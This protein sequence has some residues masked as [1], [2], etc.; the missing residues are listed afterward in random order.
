MSSDQSG[1]TGGYR[2]YEYQVLVTVWLALKLMLETRMCEAIEVEP[3]SN[4]DIQAKLDVPPDS[5]NGLLGFVANGIELDVQVKSR[6]S[7]WTESEFT[8]VITGEPAKGPK[9]KRPAAAKRDRAFDRLRAAKTLRYLLVTNAQLHPS[10]RS[11][12][13]RNPGDSSAANRLP[14][15]RQSPDVTTL[16]SRIGVLPQQTKEHLQLQISE[17]LR[18]HGHVQPSR[19]DECVTKLHDAVRYRLLKEVTGLWRRE[20][21]EATLR[22]YG[23]LPHRPRELIEPANMAEI[24]GRLAAGRLLLSGPPGTG[25][26]FVA[27]HLE[28]EHRIADEAFEIVTAEAGIAHIRRCLNS[29]GL[30]LFVFEDPWGHYRLEPDADFWRSELPKLL[31]QANPKKRFLVTSRTGVKAQAMGNS[32]P[33]SFKEAEVAITPD[34]Y[35]PDARKRIV[36][37]HLRDA[38]AWQRDLAEREQAS[39]A[40]K[41]GAPLSLQEFAEALRQE[42]NE[43]SVKVDELIR[44]S[45]VEVISRTC[46]EEVKALGGESAA[47]GVALWSLFMTHSAVTEAMAS[48]LRQQLEDG[49]YSAEIDPLKLLRWLK[50]AGRLIPVG[51]V[52]SVHPTVMQGLEMLIDEEPARAEKVLSVLLRALVDGSNS[53]ELETLA[54][55]IATRNLPIPA[56]AQTALNEHLRNQLL[57]LHG[58]AWQQAFRA[59]TKFSTGKDPVSSLVK[60]LRLTEQE[61]LSGFERWIPPALNPADIEAI[62]MAS[63]TRGVAV[64]FIR[65]ILAEQ[66]MLSCEPEELTEFFGQ[67]GWDLSDEFFDVAAKALDGRERIPMELFVKSALLTN[68]PRYDELLNKALAASD[69]LDIWYAD[70]KEEVRQAEQC[71]V[72]AT[73]ASYVDEEPGERH[74]P[75]HNALVTAVAARRDREG[76]TWLVEHPCRSKLTW[77]WAESVSD[78]A[79]DAELTALRNACDAGK[80][81]PFWKALEIAERS[82]WAA[83]VADG[84]ETA[85]EEDLGTGLQTVAKLLNTDEWQKILAPR[86]AHLPL[87]RKLAFAIASFHG[88]DAEEKHK[89]LNTALFGPE[90][91]PAFELCCER[92]ELALPTPQVLSESTRDF[93]EKIVRTG[94]DNLSV[95]GL[96]VLG[97]P[98][99]LAAD[100]LPSLL[101]SSSMH[102]RHNALLLA[103]EADGFDGHQATLEALS[104]EDYR[105][106]RLALRLLAEG[107][108][109]D[110]KQ[111]ILAMANDKSAPVRV[112][113]AEAIGTHGWHEGESVL[114]KLIYDT[115]NSTEG[116][117]FRFSTPNFHVARAA[118]SAL[119][120]LGDLQSETIREIVACV[121]HFPR[122]RDHYDMPD[123]A[124]PYE[125]LITLARQRDMSIPDLLLRHLRDDW[126]VEGTEQSGYPL[127]FAAAWSLVIQLAH[128]PAL[129]KQL[130]PA[131]LA[132]GASH[133]D[134]RLAGPCL[135]AI[136]MLG[137]R[138][139]A[140]I[141]ALAASPTFTRDR[142]LIVASN[143]PKTATAARSAL[144]AWLPA[145][146]PQGSFLAWAE[147]N[148]K[149]STDEVEQFLATYADV[150]GW[151][152]KIRAAHGIYPELRFVLHNR[153][154]AVLGTK[155]NQGD[156][157]ARHLPK[158]IPVMTMRSMFGGE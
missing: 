125:L 22:E 7:Q 105:C 56:V 57:A 52:Y 120:E 121:N 16:A 110:G 94:P 98:A 90:L 5:A 133:T 54:K 74:W 122:G 107:A 111:R 20:E 24:R 15:K 87:R 42:K 66:Q 144:A 149:S 31:A 48:T 92:S 155:L 69:A 14:T 88:K 67:F 75:I 104:D 61:R 30:H 25:K 32:D 148:P 12:Q 157:F 140:Q 68:K 46:A 152:E 11:F 95:E 28:H 4:E 64:N 40:A 37:L 9:A 89:L 34:H 58:S 156:L 44:R 132:E 115:R 99:K 151:L 39:I 3:A 65:H 49:G 77:H 106:R 83:A 62:R 55:Y 82:D 137:N 43:A 26:T 117:S 143:L 71:E 146:S 129:Q 135:A 1:G 81:R 59:L 101:R 100:C 21:L 153:L 51:G 38:A 113:C 17:L 8:K 19:I 73:H 119:H 116:G 126:Y 96:R 150:S 109:K 53:A 134:D 131:V 138:S 139:F 36:A 35:P 76:F 114:T 10:L 33:S 29:P 147:A 91:L 85:P 108:N 72:D 78:N 80:E 79:S 60:S 47:A 27:E 63:E 45:N 158:S 23:G 93:V 142:A 112:A 130:D 97:C 6:V 86:V 128:T 102:T 145:E 2:G 154:G 84:L 41:L 118:A 103:A 50:N 123:I 127:R 124:V 13:V 70:F 141:V 18:R 136:G